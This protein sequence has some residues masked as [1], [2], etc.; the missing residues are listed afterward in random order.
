[1]QRLRWKVL[2]RFGALP[3]ERRA[4]EMKD[5]DYL[6]CLVNELLD[7]EEEL[8][9]MCPACRSRALEGRCTACGGLVWESGAGVNPSFDMERFT[10]M[11]EGRR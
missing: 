1:M 4:R 3:T 8:E 5:R 7:Q 10:A 11:K 2:R 6:W 9:Q